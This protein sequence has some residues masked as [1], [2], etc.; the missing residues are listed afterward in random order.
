LKWFRLAAGILLGAMLVGCF[1]F[2]GWLAPPEALQRWAAAWTTLY[3]LP[4]GGAQ[5]DLIP[6]EPLRRV[7]FYVICTE[8]CDGVWRIVAVKGLQTTQL[9]NLARMLSALGRYPEA[10][11][12]YELVLVQ[13]RRQSYIEDQVSALLGLA[14]IA[15]LTD[16]LQRSQR[17]IDEA[18]AARSR[19]GG[20]IEGGVVD[21]DLQITQAR[22]WLRTGRNDEARAVFTKMLDQLAATGSRGSLAASLLVFRSQTFAAQNR[23]AEALADAQQALPTARAAQGDQPHSFPTGQVW[24]TLAKLQHQAGRSAEARVSLANALANLEATLGGNHR[25]IAE[26][27]ELAAELAKTI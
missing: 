22:L 15:F 12:K 14:R 13:A 23:I 11:E 6:C 4:T 27:R 26:G 3:P 7:R 8:G 20:V 10:R 9:A 24:L 21:T 18:S 16:D 5:V 19:E 17:L 1:W 2:A 25:L